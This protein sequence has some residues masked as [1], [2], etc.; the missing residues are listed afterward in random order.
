MRRVPVFLALSVLLTAQETPVFRVGTRL[1]ELSVVVTGK[2]GKPLQDLTENDFE[3]LENGK[4]MPL[5]FFNPAGAEAPAAEPLPPGVFSNRPEYAPAPPRSVTVILLDWLNT[6][7]R[8]QQF[9][10]AQV[11]RFLKDLNPRDRVAIYTLSGGLRVAHDFSDDP[12]SLAKAAEKIRAEWP[13]AGLSEEQLLLRQAELAEQFL[14]QATGQPELDARN[15]AANFSKEL[16]VTQTLKQFEF[17]AQRLAGLP[18]RKNLVWVSAGIP[19]TATWSM[20]QVSG[21]ASPGMRTFTKEFDRAVR[22][23]T[24][25]GISVYAIDA[26]GLRTDVDAP[27]MAERRTRRP[28]MGG[29]EQAGIRDA[30][31]ADTLASIQGLTEPTGGRIFRNMNELAGGI[32]QALDEAAA[33]YTLAYYTSEDGG[34]RPRRLEIKLKRKDATAYYRHSVNPGPVSASAAG[35]EMLQHPLAATGILVNAQVLPEG[36]S[37]LNVT[38]QIDPAGLTLKEERGAITG[39]VELYYAIIGSDGKAKVETSKAALKLTPEQMEK[40]ASAGL[41]LPKSLSRPGNAARLRIVV[42]DSGSGAAGVVDADL[43]RLP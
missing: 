16:R 5:A 8:D 7:P 37:R 12:A 9:A 18:G 2:D 23:V 14:A 3:V 41:V 20:M 24:D 29:A 13:P 4:A 26:R 10:R 42:R 39:A 22:A 6:D 30:M 1:V 11:A 15:E 32:R 38:V 36:G 33:S 35:T 17:I 43:R 31:A 25:A 19:L 40:I 27:A 28:A 34:R 21:A